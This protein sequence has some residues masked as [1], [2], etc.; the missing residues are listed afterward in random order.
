MNTVKV[1]QSLQQILQQSVFLLSLISTTFLLNACDSSDKNNGS[2]KSSSSAH[3]FV[4]TPV[5]PSGN[6]IWPNVKVSANGTKSLKFEWTTPPSGTTSYKLFK[7][8]DSTSN[9]LQIGD[10]FTTL[11]ISDAI[12]VHLTDWVN[13]RYKIQACNDSATCVDS[14]EIVA[15]SA[16]LSAISYLKA[17]NTE[18]DD[19]FGWSLTISGDGKTMAVGA[20]AEDSNAIGVNGE[21]TSNTSPN[22]GAVYV[23]I[24]DDVGNWQQQAYLKASNTE[25]PNANSYETLA[26]DR[27]GY[28]VALSSDGN[29][30]AVSAILEDSPSTGVNCYQDDKVVTAGTAASQNSSNASQN[31]S[32]SSQNSSNPNVTY[33]ADFNTGAVY[34]FK[35]TNN[36]WAQ[37]AYIKAINFL[38]SNA[39]GLTLAIAG[40]GKT[41]AVGTTAESTYY[42]G[43]YVQSSSAVQSVST[44]MP[45][46]VRLTVQ[47][48]A[49]QT[50]QVS[51][52]QHH[53][54][55]LAQS[56]AASAQGQ[57]IFTQK[58]VTAGTLKR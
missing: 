14:S 29:T 17:S 44:I 26:N 46:L 33:H 16:M 30:L 19:W 32:N 51:A 20:P 53:P 24:K 54:P 15:N 21:Q 48:S 37:N 22:S 50:V 3:S 41:L 55:V 12:S 40:D 7:K 2:S 6:S 43:I 23:F 56:L 58:T 52:L 11:T 9:Y 25:Q 39:F 57:C 35:R 4:P 28:Q 31:S 38:P 5:T 36:L 49:L 27:F 42:A 34:I 1:P 13:T 18:A 45:V 8:A 47:V 10:S